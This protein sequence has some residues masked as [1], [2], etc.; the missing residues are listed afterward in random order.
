MAT[1]SA[2]KKSSPAKAAATAKRQK[3]ACDL[4]DAD[5]KA[6]KALFKEYETLTEG[7]SRSTAKKRALADSICRELTVHATIE[8]EIFYPAAR[9]AIKDDALMNEATVEH[10]SAKDLIAQIRGMDAGDEIFDARVTVL[11]E[12]ID[13]HVKEERTEMFPKVRATG[14][15]LVKLGEQL[16]LR[17]EALMA[18]QDEHSTQPDQELAS[19]L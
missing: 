18:Q 6:V 12:Y 4:L 8:E 1:T 9:Q 19:T 16:Q 15:D 3:D 14:L 11:G 2:A 7:R 5:H 10:A 13:H 17:K